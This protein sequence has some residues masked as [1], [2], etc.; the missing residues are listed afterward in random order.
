[1]HYTDAPDYTT[2]GSGERIYKETP[3]PSSVVGYL[4][5]NALQFEIGKTIEAAG[6][7]L[8]VSGAADEAAGY[9]SQLLQAIQYFTGLVSTE[10]TTQKE[11]LNDLMNYVL[12]NIRNGWDPINELN[13]D[14]YGINFSTRPNS[15]ISQEY[16]VL[17]TQY[18]SAIVNDSESSDTTF[19]KSALTSFFKRLS[20]SSIS[21]G[22][23]V[24]SLIAWSPGVDGGL[25][26]V[27]GS[28]DPVVS[29]SSGWNPVYLIYIKKTSDGVKSFDFIIK[30]R[31][32]NT[33]YIVNALTAQGYELLSLKPMG[34]LF[35]T[36]ETNYYRTAKVIHETHDYI[37]LDI[38]DDG[39]FEAVQTVC[40]GDN[41]TTKIPFTGFNV[42]GTDVNKSLRCKLWYSIVTTSVLPAAPSSITIS[43]SDN[44]NADRRSTLSIPTEAD[45]VHSAMIEMY[46]N[47]DSSHAVPYFDITCVG[48]QSG[49]AACTV[50]AKILGFYSDDFNTFEPIL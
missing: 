12:Y 7:T 1:M 25:C 29:T 23:P 27:N 37:K 44:I 35:L 14:Y 30:I 48:G 10:V 16:G 21:T 28:G 20:D 24:D 15:N 2:N 49:S 31:G 50:D 13:G 38:I 19:I 26:S 8:R 4:H 41:A 18:R 17:G 34:W 40:N 39:A 45:R 6:I 33:D 22:D 32:F 42:P 5:L 11:K 47:A 36:D 43:T 46:I 3:S 9:S